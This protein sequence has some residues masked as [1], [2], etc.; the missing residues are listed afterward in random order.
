MG[1]EK[2]RVVR[3]VV[4]EGDRFAVEQQ[5]AQSLH[6]TRSWGKGVSISARTVSSVPDPTAAARA[7]ECRARAL[8][9]RALSC[10]DRFDKRT[11]FALADKAWLKAAALWDRAAGDAQSEAEEEPEAPQIDEEHAAFLAGIEED[12][13]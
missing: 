10:E 7:A 12:D 8:V 5:V 6:G 3:E 11:N 9:E 2:V 4:Y 1:D 13:E